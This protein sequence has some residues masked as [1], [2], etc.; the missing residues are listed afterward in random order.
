MTAYYPRV[1]RVRISDEFL[2][3]SMAA[4]GVGDDHVGLLFAA[5]FIPVQI[6]DSWDRR[7]Y[8]E[9]VI[10]S[11]Y[12]PTVPAGHQIPLYDVTTHT[13]HDP[14]TGKNRVVEYQIVGAEPPYQAICSVRIEAPARISTSIYHNETLL[15]NAADPAAIAA[16]L[17]VPVGT[18]T[19]AG[20]PGDPEPP[21]PGSSAEEGAQAPERPE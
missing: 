2:L 5:G 21:D 1:G 16:S 11:P 9:F 6:R 7:G 13:S 10:M 3:E 15:A 20:T 19:G 14:H 18:V 12:F 4:L 17:G 8:S